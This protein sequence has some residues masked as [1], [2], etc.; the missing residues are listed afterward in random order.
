MCRFCSEHKETFIHF[1]SECPALWRDRE[2][3]EHAEPGGQLSFVSPTQLLNFSFSPRINRALEKRE[4]VDE[5]WQAMEVRT[6]SGGSESGA[7]SRSD[8]STSAGEQS[9]VSME[10]EED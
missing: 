4:E 8:M 10:A 3:A 7:E 1:F 9:D 5:V 2:E 6:D